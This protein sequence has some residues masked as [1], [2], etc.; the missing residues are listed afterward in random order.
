MKIYF[1]NF[2]LNLNFVIFQNVE[3]FELLEISKNRVLFSKKNEISPYPDLF[4]RFYL[5]SVCLKSEV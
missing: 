2:P 4:I 3:I 1:Y 5:G